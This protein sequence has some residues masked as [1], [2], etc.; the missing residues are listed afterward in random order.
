MKKIK[1]LLVSIIAL[2]GFTACSNKDGVLAP[3][4]PIAT[5]T[6]TIKELTAEALGSWD[7]G[8]VT[9]RGVYLMKL[10]NTTTP[11]TRR[12]AASTSDNTEM[13]YFSS[14]DGAT[15][16]TLIVNAEDHRPVQ[17]IMRDGVLNFS[18]L[19]DEVLELTFKREGED[20]KYI[21]Q[22]PY[23]KAALDAALA[24]AG[25]ENNL[26]KALFYFAMVT[27][28]S[29]LTA[30]PTIVAAATYFREIINFHFDG[31]SKLTAVEA[32]LPTGADGVVAV[33]T[34]ADAFEAEVVVKVYNT[35]TIWTGMASFKVG[36]SSCTLS[37]TILCAD[38]SFAE[39]GTFGIVCDADPAKLIVGV[40]EFEGNAILK[41]DR[42]FEVDFRGFKPSSKYYYRAFYKFN[43]GVDYGSL[44]LDPRQVA[45]DG[46]AYDNV[47]KEFTTGEY[48]YTVDVVMLMDISGSMSDEIGM[49]KDNAKN[50]YTMFKDSCDNYGINL[51]GLTTQVVTFSD[52]NV[53]GADALNKSAVY[54]MLNEDEHN[55]FET[56]VNNIYLA[57]GGDYP[58]S[59]LEALATA[60]MRES[61]GPD[62]GLHR[63]VFILWTDATYLTSNSSIWQ[64]PAVDASGNP[65]LDG[66]NNPVYVPAYTAF[67]YEQVKAMWD[68]MPSGRRLILFAPKGVWGDSNEGD[69]ALMDEWK[70]VY[71]EENSYESFNNFGKSLSYII[72]EMIGKEKTIDAT[73]S[74]KPYKAAQNRPIPYNK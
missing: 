11:S 49:V 1:F 27:D 32:G 54:N 7:K 12:K 9:E 60:F 56:Y 39:I 33:A 21:D 15:R 72:Q 8:Y 65:V 74:V 38:P 23:N 24:A 4:G 28:L 6:G 58:E 3:V 36:G 31:S 35:I 19:S 53:D 73:S 48:K 42:N 17:L 16:A 59:G 13:L 69:W 14:K 51:L 25:Y 20:I 57:G 43:P 2:I 10:A 41:D 22:I 40:A 67:T 44:V 47:I 5:P 63:Q 18:F 61:W 64:K 30:Y 34:E 45:A 71:H 29:K 26:Q 55:A 66:E 70:N 50:F 46:V 52:I 68:G 37:G 62:D